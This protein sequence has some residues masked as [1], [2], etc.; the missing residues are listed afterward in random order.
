MMTVI[1]MTA[2]N[3]LFRGKKNRFKCIKNNIIFIK[4][5]LNA[6]LNLRIRKINFNKHEIK[7]CKNYLINDLECYMDDL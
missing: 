1:T 2:Y 7:Y 4:N 5:R 6:P 3:T